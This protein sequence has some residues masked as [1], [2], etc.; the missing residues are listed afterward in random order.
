MI[1]ISYYAIGTRILLQSLTTSSKAVQDDTMVVSKHIHQTF[2]PFSMSTRS[3]HTLE[4][5]K[6]EY[7]DIFPNVNYRYWCISPW[8][9]KQF[10]INMHKFNIHVFC[11]APC[12]K[13][14]T[15]TYNYVPLAVP[16]YVAISVLGLAVGWASVTDAIDGLPSQLARLNKRATLTCC[17]LDDV[18]QNRG[19]G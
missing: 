13:Q 11:S 15:F 17:P 2:L 3:M 7:W 12:M 8:M 19:V 16:P 10:I 1:S 9:W 5:K 14:W 4:I 6:Y 18:T